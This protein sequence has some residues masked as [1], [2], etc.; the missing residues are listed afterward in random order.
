MHKKI[1]NRKMVTTMVCTCSKCE[2]E[3]S[4][5]KTDHDPVRCPNCQTERWDWDYD[6]V[7]GVKK[8]KRPDEK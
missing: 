5:R 2:Y 4:P 7:N 3:W 8:F 1:V 6:V